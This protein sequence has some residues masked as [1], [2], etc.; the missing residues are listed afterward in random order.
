MRRM[1]LFLFFNVLVTT[2]IQAQISG[3]T[4]AAAGSPVTFTG[5][6]DKFTYTWSVGPMTL[7][8]PAAGSL[9]RTTTR[10]I[11][12][13]SHTVVR[14]DNGHWYAFTISQNDKQLYRMDLGSDPTAA[15]ASAVALG[16]FVTTTATEFGFDIIKD[17]AS[18]NWYGFTVQIGNVAPYYVPFCKR[19][20]FGNSLANTPTGTAMTLPTNTGCQPA[21]VNIVKYNNEWELFIGN[22]WGGPIRIDLGTDITNNTPA[23]GAQLPA[24]SG[25]PATNTA[26]AV[27]QQ[28]GNWYAL[29]VYTS[30][31]NLYRFDFGADLK[32]NTPTTTAVGSNILGTTNNWNIK[33]VPGGDCGKDLFAYVVSNNMKRLEFPGGDI[34]ATPTVSGALL[35]TNFGST[36]TFGLYPYVYNGSLYAMFGSYTDN[37]VSNVK[38]S[39]L[40]AGVQH[41]YNNPAMTTTFAS[42]GTYTVNLVA[43]MDG[44]G[45]P[46]PF[47]HTITVTAGPSQPGPY[48]AAPA[49]VCRGDAGVTYTVPVVSGATGYEWVYSGGTGVTFSGTSSTVGPTNNLTFNASATSGTL[50]VRAVN[51]GGQSTYRDTAIQVNVLPTVSVSPSTT[52]TICAGDSVT[53]TATA[54]NVNFQWK[55][56]GTTNVGTAAAYVAKTQADYAV[57]VTDKTTGC[58]ATSGS[59]SVKVNALPTVTVSPSTTQ[60]ICDGDS[61]T[62]TATASNVNYQWKRNGTTNV[63][64]DGTYKAKTQGSY[65]VTVTDKTTSCVKT[66][67]SVTVNVSSLPTVTVSPSTTQ[68]ICDGDSVTLTATASN[69]NYQWKRNGTTNVGTDG[70]YKAKTQGNYTVTVT[71]KT[72]SCVKTSGSVTVNVSS[73]PT[74]TVSPSTAQA[75]CDGDSVRLTATASNVNYQW[76]L[77]GTTNVGTASTYDANT[78]GSYTVTVTDKTTSCVKTSGSVTVTVNPLPTATLSVGGTGIACAGDSVVLTAGQGTGYNYQWK[79]GSSNVGTNSR[80]YGAVTTGDY[81]VVVTDGATQCKDSTGAVTVT[82]LSRPSVTLTPGDTSFCEGGVVTLEVSTQDTGLTYVW[83]NDQAV[84][85]L[86]TASFLEINSTG[87][88]RVIVGRSAVSGCEDSTNTVTVTVHPLPVVSTTWDGAVLHAT[89]G[90]ASYQWNTGT[91][92]IAGATD[93]TFEPSS[94][95]DYS[96]AVVD[97]NGCTGT[98]Q[99]HNVT[100]GIGSTSPAAAVHVYPNP[101]DGIVYI[102]SPVRVDALLLSLDGRLLQRYEDAREINLGSYNAGIYLLRITDAQGMP[103][104][105]ERII[106]R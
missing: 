30:Y 20:E 79:N 88:Y 42:G 70:T 13:T 87:V 11:T 40:P 100:L 93:S 53:L 44:G 12:G 73:L 101:S 24:P 51:A 18:G 103:V 94:N 46:E 15:A 31:A 98:S 69:V 50:R 76:K 59:V 68:A 2:A 5:P 8:K 49:K 60:T 65:T 58:V 56:D 35:S 106:K 9:V 74:V 67:G 89:P 77:N 32:N 72:T 90:Y 82:V 52:Q 10:S 54:S 71:D 96:V 25:A 66:S 39:D 83:K 3:P 34:T 17:S 80:T 62:L 6:S 27:Y 43:N 102:S 55:R 4:T 85:P 41:K 64:T 37:A 63:G 45:E 16:N 48:T 91:Q 99:L 61:V 104:H 29:A 33:I 84:V 86:A 19:L 75:I 28:N 105:H 23:S 95:G 7:D 1:L 47:C 81:K 36:L 97:S 78:Q 26:I 14:N 92:G 38:L 57:T 21:N 22:R